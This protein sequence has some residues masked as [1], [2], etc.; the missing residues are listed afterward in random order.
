MA[1]PARGAWGG[2]TMERRESYATVPA[3]G[4]EPATDNIRSLPV[5]D[6]RGFTQADNAYFDG[7]FG[8]VSPA[9]YYCLMY[10]VRNTLG[11]HR[12]GMR[13]SFKQLG[14]ALG[15]SRNTAMKGLQELEAAHIV[16]SDGADRGRT[17]VRTYFLLPIEGWTL[18][19]PT[20]PDAPTSAKNELDETSPNS[21]LVVSKFGLV[22]AQTSPNFGH[23]IN[24]ERKKVSKESSVT[25][26]TGA[27]TSADA[28]PAVDKVPLTSETLT[29]ALS[30]GEDT[31]TPP[32][33]RAAP[34]TANKPG[35]RERKLTD[36]K[37]AAHREE[38]AWC[39][40]VLAELARRLDVRELPRAGQQKAA[41]KWFYRELHTIEDGQ[42]RLWACYDLTKREP[43]WQHQTLLLSD[44]TRPF[45][46]YRRD[47]KGYRERI[48]AAGKPRAAP[49][50][51]PRPQ[52]P[53][54]V[55]V[56]A[57][58]KDIWA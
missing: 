47:P 55:F 7:L 11:Y 17:Q 2:V 3:V 34:P 50:S 53:A 45:P 14:D 41:A 42:K 44:L 46:E 21:A 39:G 23:P 1:A 30:T 12:Q 22:A 29:A 6:R 19:T 48:E 24:K 35:K 57:G 25:N 28:S 56:P 51:T 16:G 27:A 37:L 32:R 31:Q 40:E 43:F 58:S 5:A 49:V 52:P 8:R 36:E 26:V 38:Q 13:L 54:P 9:A 33:K 20:V 10:V 18:D 4:G 15:L